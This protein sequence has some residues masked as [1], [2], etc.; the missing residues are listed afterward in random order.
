MDVTTFIV[1]D[2]ALRQR[3]FDLVHFAMYLVQCAALRVRVAFVDDSAQAD[4][5][6]TPC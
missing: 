1:D 4:P 3:S 6:G 5:N 2:A